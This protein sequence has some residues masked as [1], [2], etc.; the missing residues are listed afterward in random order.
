MRQA[1]RIEIPRD[2]LDREVLV[3]QAVV[4]ERDKYRASTRSI[5]DTSDIEHLASM[6]IK[7]ERPAILLGSQV[8]M[9]RGHME[10]IELVR[11]LNIPAYFNGAARGLLP[12]GDPHHFHRTR[13]DAFNKDVV[14]ERQKVTAGNRQVVASS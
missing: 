13:R 1:H 6:L 7:S 2:V 8:W 5:G 14:S 12:P 10:A 4:P 11:K 9:S 3:E